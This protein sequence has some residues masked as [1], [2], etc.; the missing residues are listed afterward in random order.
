LRPN[1]HQH[2]LEILRVNLYIFL[3]ILEI[4]NFRY[5]SRAEKCLFNKNKKSIVSTKVHLDSL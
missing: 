3:L 5:G 2:G 1:I 4:F